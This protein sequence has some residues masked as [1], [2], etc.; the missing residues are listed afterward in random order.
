[1]NNNYL[2]YFEKMQYNSKWAEIIV[3]LNKV[4]TYIVY[5]LFIGLDIYLFFTDRHVFYKVILTTSISFCLVSVF[6]KIIN[7]KRPYEVMDIKPLIDK[8]TKG[9]SF[10]S[11]HIFSIYIIA[12][13]YLYI[14]IPIGVAL[15]ILGIGLAAIRVLSGVHFLRDVIWGMIIGIIMGVLGM[16]IF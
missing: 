14:S 1:M 13:V 11:R 15:M 2:A 4:I 3:K 6:R 12:T 5:L 7:A 9:N 10:P 16:Y 8:N